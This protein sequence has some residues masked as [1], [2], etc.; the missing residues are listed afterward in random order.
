MSPEETVLFQ[1][2]QITYNAGHRQQ[3]YLQFCDL[4]LANRE[5][6]SLLCW[7]GYSTPNR[8]EA[9]RALADVE[10]LK[11]NH[12]SL[13]KLRDRVKKLQST[14]AHEQPSRPQPVSRPRIVVMNLDRTPK[15][16]PAEKPF[17]KTGVEPPQ[18]KWWRK[19]GDEEP[20][21]FVLL[22]LKS[23]ARELQLVFAKQQNQFTCAN[24][25][26]SLSETH[27]LLYRPAPYQR[28][29]IEHS[30]IPIE[31]EEGPGLFQRLTALTQR[32]VDLEQRVAELEA[33]SNQDSPDQQAGDEI[34]E[35]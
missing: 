24:W 11:P 35:N 17:V 1:Q 20:W 18:I 15:D 29:C 34:E 9:Q 14:A 7:I 28:Y 13:P 5:D 30:P 16:V 8:D 25:G 27:Y 32:I 19:Q 12:P 2:A 10:R 22:P 33:R 3:A 26:K 21:Q 6:T 4:Y 31:T 23:E